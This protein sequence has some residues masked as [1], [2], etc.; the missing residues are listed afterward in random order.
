MRY[1][2][3]AAV[4]VSASLAASCGIPMKAYDYPNYGF[5]ADFP[6]PPKVEDTTI[7]QNGAQIIVLD[8]QNLGRDFAITVTDVD[9]ARD[10][11]A[12]V[13]DEAQAMAK[14]VGGEVT[15]RT[16]CSTAE[17][18]L[19]RELV[20]RKN[21]DRAVRARYYRSGGR[22]YILTAKSA[23]GLNPGAIDSTPVDPSTESGKDSDPAV[24]DFLTSFHVTPAAKTA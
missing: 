13:E 6:A 15:Y 23:M 16:Y 24:N 2:N 11:D 9:P 8:A 19:G 20:I 21:G 5:T 7:A 4:I 22:F 3:L 17:G 12:L 1:L 14:A 10:L 18:V